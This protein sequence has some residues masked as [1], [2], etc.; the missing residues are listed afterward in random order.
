VDDSPYNLAP[1]PESSPAPRRSAARYFALDAGAKRIG[2]AISD[3]LGLTAQPLLTVMRKANPREDLRSLSR[4][5]R[6]H[7]C[8]EFLVGLPLQLSG[9]S[10]A[11]T[12]RVRRFATQLAEYSGLPVRLWDERLT[13]QEA[14]SI[15]YASGRKRQEHARLVDQVAAAL[16]LQSFL[17]QPAAVT[18]HPGAPEAQ[19]SPDPASR[20][21]SLF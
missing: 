6:Q 16:I 12:E 7:G 2:V 13:T 11:Q 3:P 17:D 14:H 19:D 1:S 20:Q 9:E 15:L 5:A 18:T 21:N 8:T 4:L 10:S